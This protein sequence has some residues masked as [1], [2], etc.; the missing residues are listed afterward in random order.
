GKT[1]VSAQRL[2]H[3]LR[4]GLQ[5]AQILVLSFSNS[6]VRTLTRRLEKQVDTDASVLEDLRYLAIRTFDSWTF[7]MLRLAGRSTPE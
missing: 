2:I 6:A 1:E 3:L 4:S 7:R 5:P